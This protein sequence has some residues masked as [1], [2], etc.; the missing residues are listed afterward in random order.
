MARVSMLPLELQSAAKDVLKEKDAAYWFQPEFSRPTEIVEK[1]GTNHFRWLYRIFSSAAHGGFFGLRYFRDK[2]FE[3][4]VNPRLPMGR[5]GAMLMLHS[6][7]LLVDLIMIRDS[8]QKLG[9]KENE[10]LIL[11]YFD[12]VIFPVGQ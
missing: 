4:S 2:P 7:S 10:K 5:A 6:S 12:R 11:S 8:Y 9:Y 1:Y 3:L